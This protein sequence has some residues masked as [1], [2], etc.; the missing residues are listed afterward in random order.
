MGSR[1]RDGRWIRRL[2]PDFRNEN[3]L[4]GIDSLPHVT[5]GNGDR[6]IS[7]IL[8]GA[9]RK[10]TSYKVG[11][12][13]AIARFRTEFNS[14]LSRERGKNGSQKHPADRARNGYEK[15]F[16]SNQTRRGSKDEKGT[17]SNSRRILEF[18]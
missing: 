7:G 13:D 8:T 16:A 10:D 11:L 2:I 18:I 6:S 1:G 5:P 9:T 4:S 3:D 14:A 15:A 12:K 17:G